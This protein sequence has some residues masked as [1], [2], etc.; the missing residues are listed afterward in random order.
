[1]GDYYQSYDG[2]VKPAWVPLSPRPVGRSISDGVLQL[3][4]RYFPE[5]RDEPPSRLA[6]STSFLRLKPP[7]SR[8]RAN[9]SSLRRL[10]RVLSQR[11]FQKKAPPKRHKRSATMPQLRG[12]TRAAPQRVSVTRR[13]PPSKRVVPK[14]QLRGEATPLAKKKWR[15]TSDGLS[16][17]FADPRPQLQR[18]T[19]FLF[20]R[21][22]TRGKQ[23]LA[24]VRDRSFSLT[25]LVGQRSRTLFAL[26]LSP[27][28][29]KGGRH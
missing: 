2:S 22:R 12:V 14:L 10:T 4:P 25:A 9:S 3:S 15:A 7:R 13:V 28:G 5:E 18:T 1:M 8:R 16:P 24:L 19:S 29:R 20:V 23:R 26:A 21:R 17:K 11:K 27:R 6:R